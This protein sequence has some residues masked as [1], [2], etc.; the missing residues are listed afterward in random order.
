LNAKNTSKDTDVAGGQR[1]FG[2]LH[3]GTNFPGTGN[4]HTGYYADSGEWHNSNRQVTDWHHGNE[5][6]RGEDG[7]GANAFHAQDRQG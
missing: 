5:N 7:H 3:S 1:D 2:W 6:A 4:E